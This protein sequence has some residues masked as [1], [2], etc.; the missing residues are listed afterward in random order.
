MIVAVFDTNVL[1]AAI[2]TEGICSKLLHRARAGEFSLVSSPFIMMELRRILSK[3]FHLHREEAAFAIE[4]IHEAIRQI[5]NHN[6]KI[7]NICRD[8]DDDH[9]IACALAAN[10]DYLVTGDHD[11]LEVKNC[12]GV[13][14]ITPR[15]FESLFI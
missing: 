2:I 15:D 14:I 7:E 11:L 10:A 13:Q 9:I 3:K 8:A 1:V 4:P 12:Q 5:I 6:I